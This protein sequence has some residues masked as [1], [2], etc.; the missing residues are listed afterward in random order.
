MVDRYDTGNRSIGPPQPIGNYKGT[1][2]INPWVQI[3]LRCIRKGLA[4]DLVE[5]FDPATGEQKP[6]HRL[7]RLLARPNPH[8]SGAAFRGADA[9][10][11]GLGGNSFW[12]LTP[13]RSPFET[14]VEMHLVHADRVRIV[15]DPKIGV[16][17]YEFQTGGRSW[18]TVP[19]HLV[20]H[21]REFST[22]DDFWG[23]SPVEAVRK[24]ISISES[25]RTWNHELFEEGAMPD[26]Y[27]TPRDP[28]EN[29]TARELKQFRRTLLAERKRGK[30]S[31][32]PA[33]LPSAADIKQLGMSP[34]DVEFLET[35]KWVREVVGSIYGV[36]PVLMGQWQS[37]AWSNSEAQQKMFWELCIFAHLLEFVED[38]NEE[39]APRYDMFGPVRVRINEAALEGLVESS[40][41]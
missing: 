41:A 35:L 19:A 16:K 33:I 3:A 39:L 15:P 7:A 23:L 4:R 10:W 36:P 31:K 27:I 18:R 21:R 26:S 24:D 14:P 9:T 38:V 11:L 6:K 30:R 8:T 5:V 28:M 40:T 1:Y 13:D 32:T 34:E 37:V 22:E 29:L 2:R 17:A 25:A 20:I 12:E